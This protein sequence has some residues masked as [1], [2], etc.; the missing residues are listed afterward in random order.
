MAANPPLPQV[1][2]TGPTDNHDQAYSNT[3]D[4]VRDDA[5]P[6]EPA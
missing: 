2:H 6:H 4:V 5:M 1:S 3:D